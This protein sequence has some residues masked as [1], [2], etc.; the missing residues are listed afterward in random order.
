MKD[1]P[2]IFLDRTLRE[3]EHD[4]GRI[5]VL[6]SRLVN[7]F[8]AE[9]VAV[10]DSRQ[11]FF[12]HF[13]QKQL[14]RYDDEGK[15]LS[16]LFVQIEHPRPDDKALADSELLLKSCLRRDDRLALCRE[17]QYLMLLGELQEVSA[18]RIVAR[19]QAKFE[20]CEVE[21]ARLQTRSFIC[22]D[23]ADAQLAL[24]KVLFPQN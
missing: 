1:V 6:A 17:K 24:E 22:S 9:L 5:K 16:I 7:E 18:K 23:P 19:I 11:A 3:L 14:L 12:E 21:G 2:F 15:P 20:Q 13:I 8:E 10:V 4:A